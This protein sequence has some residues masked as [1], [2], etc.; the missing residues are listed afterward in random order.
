MN[1]EKQTRKA[2]YY[3]EDR[4]VIGQTYYMVMDGATPLQKNGILPS[5]ASW[6][7]IFIKNQLK[8]TEQNVV[9]KLNFIAR[10]AYC[11]FNR[12]T[13]TVNPD[14]YPSA[15]LAWV[16]IKDRKI[17][18][19][20]IGDCEIL[21]KYKDGTLKRLL[22]KDLPE[23]D[24][25]ALKEMKEIAKEKNISVLDAKKY[26]TD[27]LIRNRKKM[28]QKGGY[29]IYTLSPDPYYDYLTFEEDQDLLEE[30]YLYTDGIALA[31]EE[32]KIYTSWQEMF[33]KS[34]NLAQEFKDIVAKAKQDPLCNLYPRFKVLDDMTMIKITL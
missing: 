15:G 30:I 7:V 10:E 1:I 8:P 19:H 6:F 22:L 3:N 12:L 34:L 17:I 23:L 25:Q 13:H 27:T 24:Q 14:Y 16:E 21:L 31:F 26:I 28:N 9:E 29:A 18:C 33:K 4:Y 20:T 32:L 2:H 11:E 5:E